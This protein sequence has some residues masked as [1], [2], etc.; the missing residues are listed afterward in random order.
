MDMV[1]VNKI[2]RVVTGN[3]M[4]ECIVSFASHQLTS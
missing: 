2:E 3:E 4:W 1:I